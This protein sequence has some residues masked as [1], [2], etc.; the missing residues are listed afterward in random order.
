MSKGDSQNNVMTAQCFELT[1]C[2][3]HAISL[4]FTVQ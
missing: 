1:Q 4:P 3:L 2:G